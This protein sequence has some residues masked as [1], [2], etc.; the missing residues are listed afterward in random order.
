MQARTEKLPV[1]YGIASALAV[2]AMLPLAPA[3]MAAGDEVNSG[4]FR[5]GLSSGF[6]EQLKSNGVRM[7]PKA[8]SIVDGSINPLTGG[9]EASLKGSLR[10]RR[11]GE[12]IVFRQLTATLPADGKR[13]YLKGKGIRRFGLL[14]RN[15]TK[16]FSLR[17]GKVTREGFGARISAIK[18]RF[19][20]RAAKRVNRKLDLHSLRRARAGSLSVS[21]QPKTV[22][23]T[24]G[25]IHLTPS[26]S[27][28][29]NAGNLAWKLKY[30]CISFLEG[31]TAVAPGFK[32]ATDP[33]NPFYLYPV[34]G[35][36]V[37]PEGNGG[38]VEQAGGLRLQNRLSGGGVISQ[39]N[40]A[41]PPNP[42]SLEQTDS[43]YNLLDRYVSA[44][45]V[46]TGH[47][48]PL[49][50]DQGVGIGSNLDLSS[51]TVSAN[52][53]NHTVAIGG[54]VVRVN[55]GAA[56]YL[57]QAFQQPSTTFTQSRQFAAG[58]LNGV[59]SMSLTTR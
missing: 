5:L 2:L 18:V 50:G 57:N 27:I 59:M 23:V 32:D 19:L 14:A 24:G 21:E 25:P 9:G 10:F 37:S 54:I 1:V 7:T 12:K 39:C 45:T 36:T 40:S 53:D 3:A 55:K 11:D 8:F 48:A 13:G 42:V 33:G 34:S 22:E 26:S 28:A 46:I 35:G 43:A 31:N 6:A 49:G 44:R 29:D 30:H 51:A 58:D 56:L 15:P 17:G 16:L 20:P 4:S 47:P 38:I 41:P 52:A